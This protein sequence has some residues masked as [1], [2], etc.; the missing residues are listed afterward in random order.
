MTEFDIIRLGHHGDGI[1]DGPVYAPRTLPGE[2]VSGTLT[3]D[4]LEDIRVLKP[5]ENRVRPPCRHYR[6]CGGCALQHASDS[7]VAEWKL[8][9]VRNALADHGLHP[10]FKPLATSPEQSR[11]RATFAARRTKQ[12]ALAGFHGHRSDII[13]PVPDCR[14]VD[15]RLA[16]FLPVAEALAVSGASRKT[17]LAVAVTMSQAGPD[18]AVTHGKPLDGP[19]RMELARLAADHDIARLSWDGETVVTRSDPVQRFQGIAVTPPPGAF[20]QATQHGEQVLTDAVQDALA[21]A[22]RIVDLFAGCG[23]F[24]LPLTRDASVH[25]VETDAGMLAAADQGWR[26]ATGLKVLTTEA[27]DLFRNPLTVD[28]LARFDGAV[29]DP[30]RA[31]AVAQTQMLAQSGIPVIAFV[32]CNPVTFA[33]DAAVLADAGYDIGPV[34]VVDQFRWSP[35]TELVAAFHLKT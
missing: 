35:H 33:R 24:A 21:G 23:T 6:S 13:T 7:F 14:V 32:S 31:G 15:R 8:E 2:R 1:A 18:V 19:L 5:S 28:E 9:F 12:G 11:R 4:R 30:P 34:Q 29:I 3:G 17:A 20:L 27:R 26:H 16:D 10:E 25:A 22:R